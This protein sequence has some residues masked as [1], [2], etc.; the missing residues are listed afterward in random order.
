MSASTA[1]GSAPSPAAPGTASR[2]KKPR[3]QRLDFYR[4]IAMLII[5]IAHIPI[6][7]WTLWIP[8][9]FGFSDATEIF[10]FCSGFASALA[11]GTVFLNKGFHLGLGRIAYR[12]WQVYWC[13]VGILLFC[14][15]LVFAIQN[16]GWGSAE[17]NYLTRPYLV[18]IFD[19]T[20][21]TIGGLLTL[22]YVPGLF[23]ILPMYLVILALIPV[24]ILAYRAAGRLGVAVL[25]IGLWVLATLA[26]LGRQAGEEDWTGLGAMVAEAASMVVWLDW[27][28]LPSRPWD[29]GTWFFNPFAW[30]LVFFTGFAFGMGWI[31]APPRSRP[32]MWIALGVVL[33]SVPLAWHKIYPYLTGYWPRALGGEFLW[34]IR[35]ALEPFYWKTWQGLFRFLHFLA[36]AYLAWYV[37]GPAGERLNRGF[38]AAE[39]PA[40]QWKK[41]GMGA[42][43][44]AVVTIPYA[45]V[46]E[47]RALLPALDR[48]FLSTVPLVHARWIGLLQIAHL[49]ALLTLAWAALGPARRA[50]VLA[51][52]FCRVVPVLRKIGTQSLAVFVVSI[53]LAIALG[54]F[55]DVWGREMLPTAIANLTGFAILTGVAYGAAWFRKQPWRG[56]A[57]KMAPS[58]VE[59]VAS[60]PV[61]R[62]PGGGQSGRSVVVSGA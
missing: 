20:G 19:N 27:L 36:L 61:E 13:H 39:R 46:E 41:I 49:V 12:I 7:Q 4:G 38:T 14:A 42:A 47:I 60:S 15:A 34:D 17:V 32:L 40:A 9:R 28:N 54:A 56:E 44:V 30:Q 57:T 1:A 33:A 52:G 31:P 62:S 10:V 48:F 37:A 18:P 8:A 53:P 24:V 55:L 51:D 2:A 59:T 58:R 21:V 6:N 11:F 23:D 43:A 5:L 45:Y 25:V 16:N 35:Q 22:T 3:D 29:V 50:W 26:G